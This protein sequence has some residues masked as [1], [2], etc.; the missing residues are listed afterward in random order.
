MTAIAIG[1]LAHN[2]EQTIARTL[3]SLF[4]QSIFFPAA[5]SRKSPVAPT[6]SA[7]A[8]TVPEQDTTEP[9][10]HRLSDVTVDLTIVANGCRDRTVDVCRETLA[11]LT[12][13]LSTEMLSWQVQDVPEAGK[14]NAWNL[15]VHRYSSPQVDYLCLMDADIEF[16]Q[17]DTI[18]RA[19][20]HLQ[21]HPETRVATDLPLKDIALKPSRG[22]LERVSLLAPEPKSSAICGQFYCGRASALRHIWM[23]KGLPV[24][25][26]FI[27]AMVVTACFTEP[28]KPER[29]QRV[30]GASHRYEAYVG[31]LPLLRHEYRLVVGVLLNSVLFRHFWATSTPALDA[32]QMVRN[33]NE[34]DPNWVP[35][36]LI[37]RARQAPFGWLVPS[38]MLFRRFQSRRPGGPA[39]LRWLL[40][41]G[42]F[43]VDAFLMVRANRQVQQGRGVG[44]W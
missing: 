31:L 11:R 4:S 22:V 29:V 33:Y 44:L 9:L 37:D 10:S 41:L 20:S 1:I 19:I 36:F 7:P 14:S 8:L 40:A 39:V 30:E 12:V 42:L 34:R 3:E 27:R 5:P 28:G 35:Q 25:D 13:G 6:D 16:L 38:G 43:A 23:P 32:A 21:Q 2:E 15:F 24:E 17:P 18:E 26:G